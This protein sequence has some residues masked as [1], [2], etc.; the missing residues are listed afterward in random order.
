MVENIRINTVDIGTPRFRADITMCTTI[1]SDLYSHFTIQAMQIKAKNMLHDKL[2]SSMIMDV[3]EV[4][5]ID[6]HN[7]VT[8][9]TDKTTLFEIFYNIFVT[10]KYQKNIKIF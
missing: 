9:L 10:L 5:D 3:N 7:K 4:N 2:E 1:I 8:K 6:I